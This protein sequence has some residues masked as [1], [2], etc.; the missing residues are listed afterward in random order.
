VEEVLLDIS[1]HVD[2]FD[3]PG[4]AGI[5]VPRDAAVP[6]GLLLARKLTRESPRPSFKKFLNVE[7]VCF[8]AARSSAHAPA[9]RNVSPWVLATSGSWRASKIPWRTVRAG[10]SR[11]H[12]MN[13]VVH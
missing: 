5:E 13:D 2:F 11:D 7:L 4:G 10:C 1:P 8:T 12:C 6:A 3:H 9:S